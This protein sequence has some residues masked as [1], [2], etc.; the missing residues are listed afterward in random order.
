MFL[1]FHFGFG[2][3][4]LFNATPQN[5][6]HAAIERSAQKEFVDLA[7]DA[8]LGVVGHGQIRIFKI[9]DNAETLE[10]FALHISPFLR[11]CAALCAEGDKRLIFSRSSLSGKR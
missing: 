1:I 7:R 3:C 11:K 4:G 8:A 9:P 5:R 2:Q 6:L 10:I